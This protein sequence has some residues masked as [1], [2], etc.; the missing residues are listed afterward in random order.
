MAKSTSVY[1]FSSQE[2]DKYCLDPL[3]SNLK[4][5]FKDVFSL[6]FDKI[7]SD[8]ARFS[9]DEC[10]V[11]I[12]SSLSAYDFAKFVRGGRPFVA[13]G[14]EHGV[15]PF[16]AYTYNPRFLEYDCYVSPTRLWA[17]R[18]SSLHPRYANKFTEVAYPRMDDL[19]S[20]CDRRRGESHSAWSGAQQSER[21]LVI[22]SWGVDF[23]TVR[24]MPD[25]AGVVYL[26][27][28]SIAKAARRTK[29]KHAK[30][31]VST[32]DDAAALI[33]GANRIF[34]DF[35]SM[36]LEAAVLNPSVYMFVDRRFYG[37]DCDLNPSFFDRS[38][39]AFGRVEHADC[40]LPIQ[41][42]LDLEGLKRALAGEAV[43]PEAAVVSWA[44]EGMLPKA[45]GDQGA[46]AAALIGRVAAALLPE[47]RKLATMSPNLLAL[48]AVESAYYDVL[49]RQPDYPA[50]LSHA[51]NWLN[52]PAPRP[53]KTI[54][55][56]NTFAQ[57]AEGQKRWVAGNFQLPEVRVEAMAGDVSE[58]IS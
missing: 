39:A 46:Q 18:L 29:L 14:L 48:K 26:V 30:I 27:H 55:L 43:D 15:A 53:A 41:R 28:P 1:L 9:V 40:S 47:K 57:S 10:P 33:V 5:Y 54:S 38:E 23:S 13:V 21:D 45:T 17:R 56:Y 6:S 12:F 32:P 51:R 58:I 3:V 52:N 31:V 8:M 34:G 35:S 16:K 50:A 25:R 42:V 44:V 19:V 24:R 36:T 2:K 4:P 22:L 11:A 20:R 37:S 49:G 7:C